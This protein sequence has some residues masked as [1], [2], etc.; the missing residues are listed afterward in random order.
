MK[1]LDLGKQWE[2][3][4]PDIMREMRQDMLAGRFVGGPRIERLE[5]ALAKY[6]GFD[7]CVAVGSGTVALEAACTLLARSYSDVHIPDLTFQAT[8]Y[9]AIRGGLTP[10]L[11]PATNPDVACLVD[12][13][14]GRLT[15]PVDLYGTPVDWEADTLHPLLVDGC[16]SLGARVNGK[17]PGHTHKVWAYAVSFYPGKNLGS[18]GEGGALCTNDAE[19]AK[20]TR[21]FINQGQTSKGKH[22]YLGCNGRMHA[23]QS[24][25]LWHGLKMLDEWNARRREIATAYDARLA[26]NE[27][28][29][30][31]QIPDGRT[32]T[33]H[34][35]PIF[36]YHR[37]SCV[38]KLEAA[39]IPY[40]HHYAEQLSDSARRILSVSPWLE[41]DI[42][43]PDEPRNSV[44]PEEVSLPIHPLMTEED[45]STVC[46][47]L[48]VRD[49]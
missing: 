16:Q 7:H 23:M 19:L 18:M 25:P 49:A 1:F 10:Y 20:Y 27:M 6:T 35:Y 4:I 11:M 48:G 3:L 15:I 30:V 42:N 29:K 13:P 45:V 39:G 14:Y 36:T 28:Y 31:L 22:R 34:V 17:R 43:M 46:K 26:D 38:S 21:A 41:D 8:M 40:G 44:F 33:R 5:A 32:P 12:I 24:I 37:P 9:A 47:A 2:P